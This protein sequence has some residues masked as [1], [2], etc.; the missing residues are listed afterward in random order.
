MNEVFDLLRV[1]AKYVNVNGA[2][3]GSFYGNSGTRY[4]IPPNCLQDALGNPVTTNVQFEAAEYLNKGD[5]IFSK[6]LPISNGEPLFSGGQIYLHATQSSIIVNLKPGCAVQANI[7]QSG[8]ADPGMTFFAGQAAKDTTNTR[9]NW[10]G[11]R[12]STSWGN[13]VYIPAVIDTISIISDSLGYCNADRFMTSPNY[14]SFTVNVAV[15]GVTV[16]DSIRFKVFT[17]YDNYKGVWPCNNYGL[18]NNVFSE[19]HVPNIPVHFVAYT[20]INRR[21]YG[22]VFAATPKTGETYTVT[23]T[24]VDPTAFKGQLNNLSN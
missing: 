21:F 15:T 12:D 5:M 14:Q 20:L 23:L 1:Q 8:K 18:Q 17:L 19:N 9:V 3:G 2:T 7:P 10:N 13:V 4:V 11:L 24:E 22:G 16:P 6:M